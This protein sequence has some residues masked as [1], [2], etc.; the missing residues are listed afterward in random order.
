MLQYLSRVCVVF[1]FYG[2][3]GFNC[4]E[5]AGRSCPPLPV[6]PCAKW[7]R[8]RR[9]KKARA[10]AAARGAPEQSDS[11]GGRARCPRQERALL[12]PG[13]RALLFFL[14]ES[15]FVVE[16][17]TFGEKLKYTSGESWQ[18]FSIEANIFLTSYYGNLGCYLMIDP[19]FHSPLLCAH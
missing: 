17:N 10:P 16:E 19:P 6:F 11:V 3:V 12:D 8:G 9:T 18:V 4:P 5:V 14:G 7:R 15:A 2:E 13:G 1:E